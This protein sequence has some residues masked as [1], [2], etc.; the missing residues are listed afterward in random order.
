[1]SALHPTP[2]FT[3]PQSAASH[4][5]A[6]IG[7]LQ[8]CLSLSGSARKV[9]WLTVIAQLRCMSSKCL[10][11]FDLAHV[12]VGHAAPHIVA[13]IPLEPSAR[14]V[15]ME[16]S[17]SSPLRQ[18]AAGIDPKVVQGAVSPA[19]RKFGPFE[20]ASRKFRCAIGHVLS[21]EY[22]QR[23]HFLRRQ[24]GSKLGVEVAAQRCRKHVA[25]SMLHAIPHDH[26]G[27][28]ARS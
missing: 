14:I 27:G 11:A 3:I 2:T 28:P 8:Q 13:A 23:Q 24:L 5:P 16:P 1:M 26:L 10:P 12:L 22:S 25:I 19:R 18:G 20:P 9:A 4:L 21:A 7:P 15:G 6:V 17:L